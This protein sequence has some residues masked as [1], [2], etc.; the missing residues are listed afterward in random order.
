[1]ADQNQPQIVIHTQY[2]KDF[3]FENPNAP[4]A[5]ISAEGQ[6]E[7]EINVNVSANP[8]EQERFFEV[9]L[10]ITANAKREDNQLFIAELSYAAVISI[11]QAVEDR[12]IH[13]LVMIEGPRMVFPFARHILSSITQAGGFMPLNIQPIDFVRIYQAGMESRNANQAV[14]SDNHGD[15]DGGAANGSAEKDS[16]APKKGKKKS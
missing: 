1:M 15:T 11:D 12:H 2:I 7:I 4:Q 3:S 5:L 13:P 10:S 6:P 16:K 9:V 14:A 8:Q